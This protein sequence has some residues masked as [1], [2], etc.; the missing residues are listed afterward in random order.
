MGEHSRREFLKGMAAAAAGAVVLGEGCAVEPTLEGVEAR[1]EREYVE[2][3]GIENFRDLSGGVLIITANEAEETGV[4]LTLRDRSRKREER[5]AG[6]GFTFDKRG[7]LNR[8][9]GKADI[10]N[11]DQVESQQV[12][13]V[14]ANAEDWGNEDLQK[15]IGDEHFAMIQLRGHTDDMPVLYELARDKMSPHATVLFGGCRGAKKIPEYYDPNH[16]I[17]ADTGTGESAVN[18]YILMRVIDEIGTCENWEELYVR[19]EENADLGSL[20]IVAPGGPGYEQ[21]A[22]K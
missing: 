7:V 4:M 14:I 10:L 13:I 1:E 11:G 20:G 3:A 19:L 12:P 21:L 15:R 8:A 16:P 9:I 18:T 22:T 2:P 6:A 5:E 17:I